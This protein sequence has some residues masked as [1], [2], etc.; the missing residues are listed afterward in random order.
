MTPI[1]EGRPFYTVNEDGK[2]VLET[3]ELRKMKLYIGAPMFGGQ[4]AGFW[5]QSMDVLKM[6]LRG[7]GF[8][9]AVDDVYNESLPTRARNQIA[10]GFLT[11]KDYTHLLFIDVDERFDAEDVFKMMAMNLGVVGGFVPMKGLEYSKMFAMAYLCGR[12]DSLKGVPAIPFTDADGR[13]S[14]FKASGLS[15][16]VHAIQGRPLERCN[17]AVEVERIGCG[18]MLVQRRVFETMIAEERVDKINNCRIGKIAPMYYNFFGD[19]VEDGEHLSEDY[20][21]CKRWHEC[22][23]RVW[24][25]EAAK[26][27]HWGNML[28]E[29]QGVKL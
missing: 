16:A 1:P 23:G 14:E 27:G 18:A 22:G 9:Y 8:E 12:E 4:C 10:A 3:G 15:Y 2:W 25:Y 29:G 13:L 11:A 17:G 26:F 6:H 7:M 20:Y 21:F 5:S 24:A 19:A 28:F